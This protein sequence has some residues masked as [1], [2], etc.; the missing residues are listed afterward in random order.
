MEKIAGGMS[1]DVFKYR[2]LIF[3]FYNYS[4]LELNYNF[5]ELVQKKLFEKNKNVPEITQSIY[6]DGK[7]IGRIEK[8]I[9]SIPVTKSHFTAPTNAHIYAN[10]LKSIHSIDI[11]CF[12][13]NAP[14]FFKYL[15]NWAKICDGIFTDTE[16]VKEFDIYGI[17][18][19]S[20]KDQAN[21]YIEG[22]H[23]FILH[24]QFKLCLSHNDFQQLNVLVAKSNP[25]DFYVIDFEYTSLNYLYY[26]IANYFSECAFDNSTIT[27]D[28]TTYPDIE[29]RYNFYQEYFKDIE[30]NA[31]KSEL[32]YIVMQFCPLVE[33]YWYIWSLIKYSQTKCSDYLVYGKIRETNFVNKLEELKNC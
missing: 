5:E 10:L 31:M 22:L 11:D 17:N 23:E 20:I 29:S 18:Y 12:K 7:L 27:Y 25:D 3:K 24:M 32:D 28:S 19:K 26:D 14:Y 9:D 13:D 8:Y 4:Q 6:V 33:Y 21:K 16:F 2:D 1:N 30:P 15:D